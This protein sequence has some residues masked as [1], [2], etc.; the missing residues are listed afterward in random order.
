MA[1]LVCLSPALFCQGIARSDDNLREVAQALG[2]LHEP[3]TRH[4]IGVVVTDGLEKFITEF[5][6]TPAE[7]GGLLAEIYRFLSALLLNR[8]GEIVNLELFDIVGAQPHPLPQEVQSS[9][10]VEQWA[11][12]T[13]RLLVFHDR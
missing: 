13:G 11:E 7:S 4:Q 2:I 3:V 9:S 8:S 12:E 10:G 1:P 5:E 6:W